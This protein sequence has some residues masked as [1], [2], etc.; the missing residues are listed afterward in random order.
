M[1]FVSLNFQER[2][3]PAKSSA[4][5]RNHPS[6][7]FSQTPRTFHSS[8]AFPLAGPAL[9][10][11]RGGRRARLIHDLRHQVHSLSVGR[12]FSDPV[13]TEG[14]ALGAAT[15]QTSTTAIATSTALLVLAVGRLLRLLAS[16]LL[17]LLTLLSGEVF[18]AKLVSVHLAL[19]A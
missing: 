14:A 19:L 16:R 10:H 11:R 18:T 13:E 1:C 5:I 12:H 15:P 3:K 6:Q 7:L 17:L 2:L 8:R 9:S 4:S